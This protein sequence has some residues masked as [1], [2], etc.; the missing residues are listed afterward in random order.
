MLPIS[1]QARHVSERRN[2][3]FSLAKVHRATRLGVVTLIKA[4][5]LSHDGIMPKLNCN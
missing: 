1:M 4:V 3:R 5:L 2:Y